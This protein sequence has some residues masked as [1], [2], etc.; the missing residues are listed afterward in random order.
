[1]SGQEI[2]GVVGSGFFVIDLLVRLLGASCRLASVINFF[3]AI[4]GGGGLGVPAQEDAIGL[5][6]VADLDVQDL[7]S[8]GTPVLPVIESIVMLV[9]STALPDSLRASLS[10]PSAPSRNE[11]S[12]R[13]S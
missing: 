2:L 8:A 4:R 12:G 11:W 6:L 9:D 13:L 7:Q 1:M 5:I 3:D 10:F